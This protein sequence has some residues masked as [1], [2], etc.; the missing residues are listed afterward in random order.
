MPGRDDAGY[1]SGLE[2][3]F[4]HPV[5]WVIVS[6]LRDRAWVDFSSLV[7]ATG[8]APNFL[9]NQLWHLRRAGYIEKQKHP[10][11][12]GRSQW[13]LTLDGSARLLSH[14]NCLLDVMALTNALALQSISRPWPQT[15][16]ELLNAKQTCTET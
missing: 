9:S 16:P 12:H 2:P 1:L 15:V 8:L 10:E 5:R 7:A 4:L 13:R 6:L 14:D 3:M 11:H